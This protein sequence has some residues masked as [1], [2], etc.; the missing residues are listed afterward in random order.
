MREWIDHMNSMHSDQWARRIHMS[1][2]YCGTSHEAEQFNDL[3]SFMEHMKDPA[4]HPGRP[5]PSDLQIDTL[6]R[7]K[8]TT[9]TREAEYP[10]PFCACIPDSI[11][12]VIPTSKPKD[13]QH[14]LHKHIASHIKSLSVLSVPLLTIQETSQ[15]GSDRSEDKQ[16][17]RQLQEG[18]KASYPSGYDEELR[19]LPLS[20][21]ESPE[22]IPH[23]S[24]DE[25]QNTYWR[26]IGFIDWY[27]AK[28]TKSGPESDVILQDFIRAQGGDSAGLVSRP[29]YLVCGILSVVE[30]PPDCYGEDQNADRLEALHSGKRNLHSRLD[31]RHN[32]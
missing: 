10:C 15:P 21:D 19:A 11:K 12:P 5:P 6:S 18:E 13:I 25:T 20:E 32:Y 8:R 17:G 3:E 1:T 7:R 30:V 26:D 23:L 4:K 29:T 27:E 2:W 14:L 24:V 31:M 16:N 22:E 9:L 28:V